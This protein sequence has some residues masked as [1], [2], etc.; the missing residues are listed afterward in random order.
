M[1]K[2]VTMVAIGAAAAVGA[3]AALVT[4]FDMGTAQPIPNPL[5]ATEEAPGVNAS[6]SFGGGDLVADGYVGTTYTHPEVNGGNQVAAGR[7]LGWSGGVDSGTDFWELTLSTLGWYSLTMRY[8]E[9]ATSTGPSS[10][11]LSYRIGAGTWVPWQTVNTTRDSNWYQLN[12]NLPSVLEN[13]ASIT[14]RAAG[15]TGGS[16]SGTY[17]MDNL[18]ISGIPE[19]STLRLVPVVGAVGLFRRRIRSR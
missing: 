11:D 10:Y 3:K 5:S 6:L 18:H 16:G 19:P 12:F 4:F 2:L 17:R 13:Q 9:R 1:K 7:A 15:F 8:Q 14:I